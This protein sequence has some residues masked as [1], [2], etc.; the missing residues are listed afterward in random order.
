MNSYYIYTLVEIEK[1]SVKANQSSTHLFLTQNKWYTVFCVK[2]EKS[3]DYLVGK[4]T[5]ADY[6]LAKTSTRD[7]VVVSLLVMTC[8]GVI[9]NE[10]VTSLRGL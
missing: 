6:T 2:E 1:L 7:Y 5:R 3:N 10:M 9:I 8:L 4:Y